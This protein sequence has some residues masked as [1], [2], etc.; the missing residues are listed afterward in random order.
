LARL[1]ILN[2]GYKA[3]NML[4]KHGEIGRIRSKL[5]ETWLSKQQTWTTSLNF[6]LNNYLQIAN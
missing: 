2:N 4:E 3:C 5:V 6:Y 1:T